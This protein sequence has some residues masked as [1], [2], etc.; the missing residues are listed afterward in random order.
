MKCPDNC[1]LLMRTKVFA[2]ESTKKKQY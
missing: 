2:V 1:Q